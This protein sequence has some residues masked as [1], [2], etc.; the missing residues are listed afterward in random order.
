MTT[1]TTAP[2]APTTAHP[3][4]VQDSLRT[5]T[6]ALADL[7]GPVPGRLPLA[8]DEF[9][10]TLG[11]AG[12]GAPSHVLG[13]RDGGRPYDRVALSYRSGGAVHQR[14]WTLVSDHGADVRYELAEDTASRGSFA[15]LSR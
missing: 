7:R 11:T 3:A 2:A 15:V 6:V 9:V 10:A 5:A 14:V 12:P 1:T 13:R 4:V 8:H